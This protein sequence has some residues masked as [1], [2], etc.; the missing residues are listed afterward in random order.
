MATG[1]GSE[2]GCEGRPV[3]VEV[4]GLFDCNGIRSLWGINSVAW[5][6]GIGWV[7]SAWSGCFS[8]FFFTWE[9]VYFHRPGY[10]LQLLFCWK[11]RER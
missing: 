4:T 11:G 8:F 9:E 10:L 5:S 6:N 7:T 1:G 2:E 3:S